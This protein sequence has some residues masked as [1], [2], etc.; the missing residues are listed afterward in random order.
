MTIDTRAYYIQDDYQYDDRVR[1]VHPGDYNMKQTKPIYATRDEISR[2]S[3][4]Q[5]F[6]STFRKSKKTKPTSRWV[7]VDSQQKNNSQSSFGYNSS[8]SSDDYTDSSG[9]DDYFTSSMESLAMRDKKSTRS[10]REKSHSKESSSRK[11]K[12]EGS[13]KSSRSKS[14]KETGRRPI[15]YPLENHAAFSFSD[16]SYNTSIPIQPNPETADNSNLCIR[17]S[18]KGTFCNKLPYDVVSNSSS[19]STIKPEPQTSLRGSKSNQEF[20][21]PSKEMPNVFGIVPGVLK[22]PKSTPSLKQ[23]KTVAFKDQRN[24]LISSEKVPFNPFLLSKQLYEKPLPACPQKPAAPVPGSMHQ[25][26]PPAYST[27]PSRSAR[28]SK[29]KPASILKS[30][31]IEPQA[32]FIASSESNLNNPLND[33][34][35][36][37]FGSSDS[38]KPAGPG[39]KLLIFGFLFLFGYSFIIRLL[40]F[41]IQAFTP[42]AILAIVI[43]ALVGPQ[44][45][46]SQSAE[47][48]T[49]AN[50]QTTSTSAT[51]SHRSRHHKHRTRIEP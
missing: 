25:Y 24:S 20:N 44:L 8:S 12:P 22:Q 34:F 41:W 21:T 49:A 2:P 28:S 7:A 1:F 13:I 26:I 10:S 6:M 17:F 38:E 4:T 40:R 14:T 51:K 39:M 18:S 19:I 46:G 42:F 43:A 33:L 15:A 45:F 32:P 31:P 9:P 29:K 3:A 11:S 35:S 5:K 27:K 16:M 30:R 50:S 47:G 36:A 37:V 48:S 23:K